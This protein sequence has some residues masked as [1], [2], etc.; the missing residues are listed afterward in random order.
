[1]WR[2]LEAEIGHT[3]TVGQV[4]HKKKLIIYLSIF[5]EVVSA[6]TI[7]EFEGNLHPIYFSS[8]VLHEI[9]TRYQFIEKVALSLLHAGRQIR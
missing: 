2:S 6:A 1:M 7:Q 8:Q 3:I 5:A 4:E 9:E